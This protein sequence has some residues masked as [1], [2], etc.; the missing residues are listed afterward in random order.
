MGFEWRP[1]QRV[2]IVDRGD[3]VRAAVVDKVDEHFVTLDDRSRWYLAGLPVS[4]GGG[5]RLTLLTPALEAALAR[6][7]RL[8]AIVELAV[9]IS[10]IADAPGRVIPDTELETT[11]RVLLGLVASVSTPAGRQEAWERVNAART[12]GV[13]RPLA[14]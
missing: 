11:E 5:R 6:R 10:E 12:A 13:R 9:I 3:V 8:R 2:V 1:G 14:G 4:G 7:G